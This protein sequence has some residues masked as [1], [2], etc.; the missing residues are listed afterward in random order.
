MR[1]NDR[2]RSNLSVRGE[3]GK[4]WNRRIFT[5]PAGSGEGPLTEPTAA[6]QPWPRE[7][8]LVP[9]FSPSTKSSWRL[10]S[11]AAGIHPVRVM[12]ASGAR[13]DLTEPRSFRR[14]GWV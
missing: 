12:N 5:V 1:V 6:A 4:V 9:H 11:G 8:A 7:R 2:Y 13:I 14:R 3:G 10:S